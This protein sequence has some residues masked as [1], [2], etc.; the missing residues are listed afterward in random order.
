VAPP[1]IPST[2]KDRLRRGLV[3]PFVGAGVS[4]AI[5][6]RDGKPLFPTWKNLLLTAA[7]QLA[8]EGKLPDE[9]IVRGN[10]GKGP[11][12][13]GPAAETARRGLPGAVWIEFLKQQF[14]RAEKEALPESLDLAREVWNL[15]SPLIVTTNYD[16]VLSWACPAGKPA[17][18]N[19]EATAEQAKLLREGHPERDTVWHLHGHIDDAAEI[20]LTPDGFARLYPTD[21]LKARYKTARTTLRQLLASRSLLFLGFSFDDPIGAELRAVADVFANTTG[22]HYALVRTCEAARLRA[23]TPLVET[24]EFTD[25][26]EPLIELVRELGKLASRIELAASAAS[27]SPN[28][29]ATAGSPAPYSIDNRPFSVPFRSKGNRVIGREA[30]LRKVREQL[31]SGQATRIGQTA[32]FEG[33]GGLGKTQLAVE[34]AWQHDEDYPNGVIWLTADSDIAAQLTGLAVEARWVAPESDAKTKLDIAQHRIRSFSDCLIVFDNVDDRNAIEPYLPLP[35]ARPHLLATSRT[36]QAGFVPVQLDLLDEEQSVALL[37]L[38]AGRQPQGDD[39]RNAAREIAR[40][41][42]RLPLA[43]EIA[44][45]YLLHRAIGWRDYLAL[46]RANPS[47]AIRARL[48]DSFTGHE[49]D[50]Y[51]TLSVHQRLLTEEPC[52]GEILDV[53]TWSGPVPMGISLLAVLL[54]RSATELFGSLALG[55]KLKLLE[56]PAETSRYGL[57]RLVRRVRREE[58]PIAGMWDWIEEILHRV[59]QWFSDRRQDFSDLPIFEAEI[60]HL[61]AWREQAVE[62][63]STGAS[64]LTWLAAYPPFHRGQYAES[65]Q[66]LEEAQRLLASH[67]QAEPELEAW[68]LNDRGTVAAK[69][70]DSRQALKFYERSLEIRKDI[71]GEG[72]PDT[73]MSLDNLGATYHQ[74]GDSK[75]ALVLH[76][77]AFEIRERVLGHNHRQTAISLNNL[78]STYR[79]LGDLKQALALHQQAFEIRERVLGREHPETAMSFSNLGGIYRELGDLKQA[80]V[81]HQQAFEMRARVLGHE[82]PDTAMSFSNLGGVYSEVG[83]SKQA[84][85]LLR[86]AFEIRKRVLGHN[87][88][89]TATSLDNLGGLYRELGDP[90]QALVLH[91]QAFETRVRVLGHDHPDTARSLNNLGST[92]WDLGEKEQALEF[93]ENGLEIMRRVLPAGHQLTATALYNLATVLFRL[94]RPNDA[95]M[96]ASEAL[97]ILRRVFGADHIAVVKAAVR[98]AICLIAV[99]RRP[100][101]FSKIEYY[102]KNPPQDLALRAE[103]AS[104]E[105]ELM[106]QPLRHGFRQPSARKGKRKSKKKR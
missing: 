84:L 2:L 52:L 104:L 91:Q 65:Q 18:W 50:L 9:M 55:V 77:E 95:L 85:V 35:T 20:L 46:L 3:I 28:V 98:V 58:R 103:V 80:L 54:G 97:T 89:D 69:Q 99:G 90:K 26:G 39:E 33:L 27:V 19:I 24:V 61:H 10:V 16:D 57:H 11:E 87:H 13:Y 78:G 37:A 43:V 70:G 75:Q 7:D 29:H 31:T 4:R 88:P 76:Q 106:R 94:A 44:G 82:H 62:I 6:R 41:L 86:Q 38:E 92:Y 96:A 68:I 47:A 74:Q 72:H 105:R 66:W 8:N 1:L 53:L 14:A 32:S 73:A 23:Q 21:G 102:R 40:E 71:L 60:D 67:V 36:E 56:R 79:S 64:R 101:A 22:P 5:L 15:G 17:L 51:K 93:Y 81:F 100:E 30:A 59:G 25:F 83:D 34:Y 42:G 48:L 63:R 49:A 12:G 45:A